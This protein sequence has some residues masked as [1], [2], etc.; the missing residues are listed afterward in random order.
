MNSQKRGGER[1]R[2]LYDLQKRWLAFLLAAAMVL[3]NAGTGIN[4]V[5]AADSAETVAFTMD[6]TKLLN[7][8]RESIVSDNQVSVSDLDFTNGKVAEFE[9]MFFGE[10]KLMEV[11]PEPEGGS[12][13]VE[14]RVFIRVPEDAD[15]MY[16]VTGAEEIIFL[17]VNNGEDTISCTTNIIRFDN[18]EEKVK[19][20]KRITVKNFD[21]AYGD[22]EVN[23]ISKPVEETTAP[24]STVPSKEE[25]ADGTTT[26]VPDES[27][28][29]APAE[30]HTTA[31]E[32]AGTASTEGETETST[33]AAEAAP[34]GEATTD[35]ETTE[36][37]TQEAIQEATE[38]ETRETEAPETEAAVEP[39]AA[40]GEPVA[41]IIRRYAP[42]VGDSETGDVSELPKAEMVKESE[43]DT[44]SE[45][46]D[47]TEKSTEKATET[48]NQEE[49]E[50][51]SEEKL[52]ETT[53][54][55]QEVITSAADDTAEETSAAPGNSESSETIPESS[56]TV[57]ETIVET[58]VPEKQPVATPSNGTEKETQNDTVKTGISG[59]VGLGNCATAKA[60]RT[61]LSKLNIMAERVIVSTV[62]DDGAVIAVSGSEKAMENIADVKAEV[63]SDTDG[64]VERLN[65]ELAASGEK[66]DW[67]AVYDVTVIDGTGN[68]TQPNDEVNVSIQVPEIVGNESE[69]GAFHVKEFTEGAQEYEIEIKDAVVDASQG[70]VEMETDS[71]SPVGAFSVMSAAAGSTYKSWEDSSWKTDPIILAPTSDGIEFSYEILNS[72]YKNFEAVI[73]ITIGENVDA[74]ELNINLQD[75]I[76]EEIIPNI[77]DYMWNETQ[78]GDKYQFNVK[79]INKSQLDYQYKANSFVYTI[80]NDGEDSGF[81]SY[82]GQII[83][84]GT[85][86]WNMG[87]T[88]LASLFNCTVDR[89]PS[90]N[91]WN[92]DN[93]K[94]T[95]SKGISHDYT[96]VEDLVRYYL[97]FYNDKYDLQVKQL[98]QF[99]D[100]VIAE[101]FGFNPTPNWDIGFQGQNVGA[102]TT[103]YE[104][105]EVAY[106]YFYNSCL[107]LFV[108]TD[109]YDRDGLDR[110]YLESVDAST[111]SLGSHMRSRNDYGTTMMEPY[112]AG[113]FSNI[114][115][116]SSNKLENNIVMALDGDYTTD[117]YQVNHFGFT[118]GFQ[119][120]KPA[121]VS[122]TVV[123]NGEKVLTGRDF[124]EDDEYT[125]SLKKNDFEVDR[126]TIKP[127]EN[128]RFKLADMLAADETG[129]QVVYSISEVGGGTTVNEVTYDNTVY[130]GMYEIIFDESNNTLIAVYAGGSNLEQ[131][132]IFTNVYSHG[133]TPE[134]PGGGSG[135]G[136]GGGGD[137]SGGH[138]A[139]PDVNGPG[140][141]INPE[142]V[143]LASLPDAP[144]VIDEDEVPLAPLP[145]TGQGTGGTT[146]T[147]LLSGLLLV[148]TAISKKKREES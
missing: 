134:T 68:E 54:A 28:T 61:T 75:Y 7:A 37:K 45:A 107:R 87:N 128:T 112:F 122:G 17:Y 78:A 86:V 137:N 141:T 131:G 94:F 96:G 114:Q 84:K 127:F 136:G 47:K 62:A 93:F 90:Y 10:G 116:G 97:D 15:D 104:L 85:V 109:S 92:L 56:E 49:T 88:A 42:V 63:M 41:S 148:L 30:E 126:I 12:V 117:A 33:E 21:A 48:G 16:M 100:Y 6:G 60:Y 24:D 35:L 14:L 124:S 58:D 52:D 121:P 26:V 140:I 2:T 143:P 57:P 74:D 34:T 119:L 83:P 43:T 144:V 71:F 31:S 36:E 44:E 77:D 135:G 9:S 132:V 23:Y 69:V 53:K 73:E 3:T 147:M 138:R 91:K 108:N 8:V 38:A 145:K 64:F 55:A 76:M 129:T 50:R 59:L 46:V 123:F 103:D 70:M 133:F 39:E 125:F 82:T 111:Y 110:Y 25:T 120:E 13:D 5:Y 80:L 29:S 101:I 105:A 51:T 95:D 102:R 66:V 67:I 139:T 72:N 115:S 79:I 11:F 99:P 27:E 22:E 106:N 20:T 146:F 118:F 113:A 89:V 1:M 32:E 40:D 65:S 142:E 130:Q 98:D 18:G 4:T 19:K 81:D